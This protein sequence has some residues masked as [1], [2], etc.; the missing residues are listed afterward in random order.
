[1]AADWLYSIHRQRAQAAG[2]Q[3]SFPLPRPTLISVPFP[4]LRPAIPEP[5]TT[6]LLAPV[7]PMLTEALSGRRGAGWC[8]L[9]LRLQCAL[10]LAGWRGAEDDGGAGA[11]DAVASVTFRPG[12]TA[13]R[14]LEGSCQGCGWE[15]V[16][17]FCVLEVEQPTPRDQDLGQAAGH[18]AV[19]QV[20]RQQSWV[21]KGQASS[22]HKDA[23]FCG[24]SR[25][26]LRMVESESK[27]YMCAVHTPVHSFLG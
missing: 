2:S 26:P 17:I 6:R 1:M 25:I 15:H 22:G 13:C 10:W 16:R 21:G 20:C 14:K 23:A 9:P 5:P 27:L 11:C 18:S 8:L 3:F 24:V 19:D 12:D 4:R 7:T